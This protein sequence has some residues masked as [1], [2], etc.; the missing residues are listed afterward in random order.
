MMCTTEVDLSTVAE[1]VEKDE[2]LEL[3]LEEDLETQKKGIGST[4]YVFD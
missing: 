1:E 3:G 2:A 4:G